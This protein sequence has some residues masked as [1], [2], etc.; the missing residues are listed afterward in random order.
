M[1]FDGHSVLSVSQYNRITDR[2][3]TDPTSALW[4][5]AFTIQLGFST[6]GLTGV[7][8][9]CSSA[10]PAKEH[11]QAMVAINQLRIFA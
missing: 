8:P 6:A 11:A 9:T 10:A 2:R 7:S 3:V 4:A 5:S 1:S